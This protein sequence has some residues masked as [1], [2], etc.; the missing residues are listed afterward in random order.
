VQLHL[1]ATNEEGKILKMD[2]DDL[3][4]IF[5]VAEITGETKMNFE[6]FWETIVGDRE[7]RL[8]QLKREAEELRP[9]HEV[10]RR[11]RD[12][13]RSAYKDRD[14]PRSGVSSSGLNMTGS[15]SRRRRGRE[16]R[17]EPRDRGGRDGDEDAGTASRY[18]AR[19]TRD[20]RGD[21]RR[22][23]DG[24]YRGTDE[25]RRDGNY[26]ERDDDADHNRDTGA[27]R[28][29]SRRYRDGGGR[30][31][32]STRG[33]DAGRSRRSERYAHGESSQRAYSRRDA[34]DSSVRGSAAREEGAR[35]Q[36]EASQAAA[37]DREMREQRERAAAAA[38]ANA[39]ANASSTRGTRPTGGTDGAT[40]A[41]DT[42]QR[43]TGG[44]S[45]TSA[46]ARANPAA[47][48]DAAAA[49]EDANARNGT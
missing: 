45:A 49:K 39:N 21:G 35:F 13:Q 48:G 42:A 47:R 31:H 17:T 28:R 32:E 18:E 14:G 11:M 22:D 10:S 30:D 25:S 44:S 8:A 20:G 24:N 40:A 23:R 5:G 3:A 37:R 2:N 27:S 36:R 34:G 1:T 6:R 29:E 12:E 19:S 9:R 16:S 46:N 4:D 26:R 33:E 43:E 38:A 15:E 7:A 41:R